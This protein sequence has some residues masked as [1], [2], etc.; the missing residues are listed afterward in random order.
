MHVIINY[1]VK[2]ITMLL[3]KSLLG[4]A[5]VTCMQ[6]CAHTASTVSADAD[7][8]KPVGLENSPPTAGVSPGA[9]SATQV[10]EAGCPTLKRDK[11][12][13]PVY[14]PNEQV[15]VI[16]VIQRCEKNPADGTIKEENLWLAMGFP[17]TA[18]GGKVDITG[19]HYGN[20]GMIGLMLTNSCPMQPV[21]KSSF[22]QSV[23]RQLNLG[24]NSRLLA[25]YP[26]ELLYWELPD[27]TD[28]DLGD[29]VE[30]R[31]RDSLKKG[32]LPMT[33][34]GSLRLKLW[35]RENGWVSKHNIY[36]VEAEVK[37]VA[38]KR[39]ALKVTNAKMLGTD[40][41]TAV[42]K[43]CENQRSV[44]ECGTLFTPMAH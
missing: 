33:E 28:A 12:P 44:S 40:E 36:Y 5:I 16:D 14:L 39:F 9:P 10:Q 25:I 29:T 37:L 6:G 43:K 3:P 7:Q 38:R 8:V 32:W 34:N 21:D 31:T 2:R 4:L 35:G 20:P 26:F 1:E 22:I 41:I 24:A 30:L 42:R 23:E 15:F 17:C 13:T 18:G 11:A 27:F 19:K